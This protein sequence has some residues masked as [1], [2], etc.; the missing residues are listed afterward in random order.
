MAYLYGS[1]FTRE[2]TRILQ[3]QRLNEYVRSISMETNRGTQ[4]LA[5]VSTSPAGNSSDV[6]ASRASGQELLVRL[7]QIRATGQLFLTSSQTDRAST[8]SRR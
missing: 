8:T 5:A 4:A 1:E 6:A 2:S 7:S 3:Q